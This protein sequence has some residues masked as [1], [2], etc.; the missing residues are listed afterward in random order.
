MRPRFDPI[1]AVSKGVRRIGGILGLF[2]AIG[3]EVLVQKDECRTTF[4][5]NVLEGCNEV[6]VGEGHGEGSLGIGLCV[7]FDKGS[8]SI[9][10]EA[11]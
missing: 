7:G 3:T 4:I 11:N 1:G 6:R 9:A 8:R 2:E 5:D 10:K